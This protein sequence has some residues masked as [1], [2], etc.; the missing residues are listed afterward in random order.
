LDVSTTSQTFTAGAPIR[1]DRDWIDIA[2]A[3][4]A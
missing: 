3:R 4:E 2:A 1:F